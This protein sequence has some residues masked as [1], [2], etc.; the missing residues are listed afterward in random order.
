M[1]NLQPLKNYMPY[2][3]KTS[4]FFFFF[5]HLFHLLLPNSF[6]PCELSQAAALT[7]EPCLRS[8]ERSQP[9]RVFVNSLSD[10]LKDQTHWVLAPFCPWPDTENWKAALSLRAEFGQLRVFFSNTSSCSGI[11]TDIQEGQRGPDFLEYHCQ[12]LSQR[13]SF[14]SPGRTTQVQITCAYLLT[15]GGNRATP[16]D[17]S[18][19]QN[20]FLCHTVC[21]MLTQRKRDMVP[22]VSL[23]PRRN[24]T[25]PLHY[26]SKS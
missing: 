22:E 23:S 24:F 13:Q 6:G 21:S 16:S 14:A 3:L 25:D 20:P 9:F 26:I 17:F 18:V 8:E 10:L 12:T 11:R 4:H 5:P 19:A 7:P 2:A 1:K 15:P